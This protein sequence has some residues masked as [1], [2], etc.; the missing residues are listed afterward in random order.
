MHN[1]YS[2]LQQ[3]ISTL[4]RFTADYKKIYKRINTKSVCKVVKS[5]TEARCTVHR[6]YSRM[7]VRACRIGRYALVCPRVSRSHIVDVQKAD[8]LTSYD[9]NIVLGRVYGDIV[10]RPGQCHREV[11]LDDRATDR[12]HL[13]GVEGGVAKTELKNLR[14]DCANDTAART[15]GCDEKEISEWMMMLMMMMMIE[16]QVDNVYVLAADFSRIRTRWFSRLI[17]GL[18]TS[19]MSRLLDLCSV[20]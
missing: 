3:R 18:L 11:T 13:A 1:M 16:R 19:P 12:Q 2:D 15:K 4:C 7:T 8:P 6:E 9:M 17:H 14:C 10:E 20:R 5:L